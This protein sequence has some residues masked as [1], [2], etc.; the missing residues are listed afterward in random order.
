MQTLYALAQAWASPRAR[1]AFRRF[2]SEVGTVLDALLSPNRIVAEVESMRALQREAD[3]L[4]ATQP[5][6]AA[7]LRW[8]AER[9]GPR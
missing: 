3:R 7:A 8:Q 1:R 5:A 4:E 6:R 9:V 2:A